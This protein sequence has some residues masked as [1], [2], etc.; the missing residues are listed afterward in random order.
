MHQRKQEQEKAERARREQK[1]PV[2]LRLEECTMETVKLHTEEV[3][4]MKFIRSI[5]EALQIPKHRVKVNGFQ[6]GSV[7][8]LLS[9]LEPTGEDDEE[10]G[11]ITAD[12]ALEE[13]TEQVED[14]NSRLRLGEVGPFVVAARLDR[15]VIQSDQVKVGSMADAYLASGLEGE[16]YELPESAKQAW[17]AESASVQDS[18][19]ADPD[20]L[21]KKAQQTVGTRWGSSRMEHGSIQAESNFRS[22]CPHS[23]EDGTLAAWAIPYEKQPMYTFYERASE[24]IA[25]EPIIR[26]PEEKRKVTMTAS[27][28]LTRHPATGT[29]VLKGK[30][31]PAGGVK[32]YAADTW[33]DKEHLGM[34]DPTLRPGDADLEETIK[35]KASRT[36]P[37][38]EFDEDSPS[39]AQ[40]TRPTSAA[41]AASGASAGSDASSSKK[42]KKGKKASKEPSS[43]H[44]ASVLAS[45]ETSKTEAETSKTDSLTDE[46]E[47]DPEVEGKKEKPKK[48]GGKKKGSQDTD[49]MGQTAESFASAA[50]AATAQ[51]AVTDESEVD[52][53]KAKKKP[54]AKPAA[55]KEPVSPS[56][57]LEVPPGAEPPGRKKSDADVVTS[58]AD[59]TKVVVPGKASPTSP[60]PTDSARA[61][62]KK[63]GGGARRSAKPGGSEGCGLQGNG[64]I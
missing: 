63:G 44:T 20:Q 56:T 38:A 39:P 58:A 33:L 19:E 51:S 53:P 60:K 59:E 48:K 2:F 55:K 46:G 7:K 41:S 62:P 12:M 3:F 45:A 21:I 14:P 23:K 31:P 49:D 61:S 40:V 30:I 22:T 42:K 26:L 8:V 6:K 18:E 25:K 34:K 36:D 64:P 50:S 52:S 4:K 5:A 27:F 29:D 28:H 35:K 32:A 37:L 1:A 9:I 24:E 54:K 10:S 13:L 15:D 11:G 17:T 57:K 47:A 16:D 43:D